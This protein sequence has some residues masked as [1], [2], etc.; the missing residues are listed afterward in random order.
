[1]PRQRPTVTIVPINRVTA[2]QRDAMWALYAPHH[3]MDRSSF[4]ARLES[5]DELA[6]FELASSAELVG[7]SGLRARVF[8]LEAGGRVAAFY[9]GVTYIEVAWRS[10]A[11]IQRMVVKRVVRPWLSPA[12]RRVYFWTDCLTYRPYLVMARNLVEYHPHR[13]RELDDEAREVRDQLGQHYYGEAYDPEHGTVRKSQARVCERERVVTA[14]DLQDP[15]IRHYMQ[16]NRNYARGDGLIAMCPATAA[17]LLH[18]FGR[19]LGLGRRRRARATPRLSEG[20]TVVSQ[21]GAQSS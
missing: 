15:D 4:E 14:A 5:L 21:E 19:K 8:D 11:L 20:S 13:E 9:M 7:F 12:Y 2:A 10:K 16:L 1:M 6:L 17:N 18:Y 3:N